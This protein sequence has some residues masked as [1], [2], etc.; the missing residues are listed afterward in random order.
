MLTFVLSCGAI[1]I[2]RLARNAR[3]A[4]D[5]GFDELGHMRQ[6]ITCRCIR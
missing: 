3:E 5:M 1:S 6:G 4:F 2:E